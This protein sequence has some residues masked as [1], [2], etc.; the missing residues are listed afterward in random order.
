VTWSEQR[1]N[2]GSLLVTM[3][4]LLA[5]ASL[6]TH[7]VL[8]FFAPALLLALPLA[9]GRYPGEKRLG[10][11][12]ERIAGRGRRKRAIASTPVPRRRPAA[13][14]PRGAAVLAAG[15]ATRAPPVHALT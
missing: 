9:F 12:R 15:L 11:L 8:L 1:L 2:L 4:W 3:T 5:L 6:G 10:R 13:T 14:T 7:D